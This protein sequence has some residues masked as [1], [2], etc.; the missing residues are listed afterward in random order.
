[1]G[2]KDI[3]RMSLARKSIFHLFILL[4]G[5]CTYGRDMMLYSTSNWIDNTTSSNRA[6]REV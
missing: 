4:V 1:M 6:T 2:P 5:T 3:A